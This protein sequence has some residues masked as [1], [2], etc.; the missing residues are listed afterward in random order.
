MFDTF[1]FD[2]IFF[3]KLKLEEIEVITSKYN[4]KAMLQCNNI[5]NKTS[6][7]ILIT[8]FLRSMISY[9]D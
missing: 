2:I 3:I 8:G 9:K 4:K 1:F 6:V 5:Y 7:P